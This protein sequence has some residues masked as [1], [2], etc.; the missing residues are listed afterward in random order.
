MWLI[1]LTLILFAVLIKTE[2]NMPY[3]KDPPDKMRE[4]YK[5]NFKLFAFNEI[6][7]AL[8]SIESLYLL[9]DRFSGHGLLSDMPDG[10]F[11]YLLAFVLMDLTLYLW[12][13]SEHAF[14]LLWGFHQVH[15]SD[16]CLNVSTSVRFHTLSLILVI[17]VKTL[18][19]ITMGLS[20]VTILFYEGIVALFVTFQHAN[21]TFPYEQRIARIFVVPR[22]HRLHHSR[23][24][25]QRDKN[26]G[27]VFSFWDRLFATYQDA[28]PA[29]IGLA[30]IQHPSCTQLLKMGF[31]SALD[32]MAYFFRTTRRTYS[33]IN[34]FL[35]FNN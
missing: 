7:L 21:I 28:R 14:K 2:K 32:S 30:A 16:A 3:L 18:F 11:K 25:N 22:L 13:R 12:H 29:K 19:F 10:P 24:L 9:V 26:F 27:V 23:S 31:V 4:S 5:T 20:A 6:T 8:L 34:E 17:I 33:V 1:F 35:H 15:H